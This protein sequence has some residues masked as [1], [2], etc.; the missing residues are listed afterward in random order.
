MPEADPEPVR[1]L[2]ERVEAP[3]TAGRLVAARVR[4]AFQSG[5]L[6]NIAD[7]PLN[8]QR[9]IENGLSRE[10]ALRALTIWPAEILGVADR[11][12]SIEVGKIANLTITRGQLFDRYARIAHV[13]VDGQQFEVRSVLPGA[14]ASPAAGT[15]ALN[16]DL[17]SG[18]VPVTL[19][20]QQEG[21]RLHGSFQGGLGS[22]EISNA[23]ISAAGEIRFTF[24]R[25]LRVKLRKHHL[26]AGLR[27]TDAGTVN[28]VGRTPGS[29]TGTRGSAPAEP[30]ASPHQV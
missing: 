1:V 14:Q 11:L 7:F 28:V 15:W 23:S 26:P 25:R 12:G 16:V 27:E 9:A 24:P 19:V 5:A 21:E 6:A 29:F 30:A 13:F 4:F 3:K 20:L 17:G 8:L 2:R 10:D 22:G 18:V